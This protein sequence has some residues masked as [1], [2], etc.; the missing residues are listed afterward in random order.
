[1]KMQEHETLV[2]LNFARFPGCITQHR[3]LPHYR[4]LAVRKISLNAPL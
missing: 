1:M 4:H 3:N 2:V